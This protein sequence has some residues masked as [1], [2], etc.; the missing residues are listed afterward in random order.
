MSFRPLTVANYLIIVR[1]KQTQISA[2]VVHYIQ[3]YASHHS[4]PHPARQL[5]LLPSHETRMTVYREYLKYLSRNDPSHD[6]CVAAPSPTAPN[7]VVKVPVDDVNRRTPVSATTFITI[8]KSYLPH[9]RIIS[10]RSDLCDTCVSFLRRVQLLRMD[11]SESGLQALT[12]T[13]EE[14]VVHRRIAAEEREYYNKMIRE[15][16][17]ANSP[18]THLSFDYSQKVSLPYSAQQVG[19]AYFKTALSV[20]VFG[21][22]EE[23]CRRCQLFLVPEGM[24][25][26]GGASNSEYKSHVG[27]TGCNAVIS[28]LHAA[29]LQ[30]RGPRPLQLRL[31]ADNCSGQN[32]NNYVLGYLCWAVLVGLCHDVE[33]SFM[34]PGHTKFSC[35]AYFGIFKSKLSKTDKCDDIDDLKEVVRYVRNISENP[36]P[37]QTV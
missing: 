28:Q 2:I 18:I 30:H 6:V 10:P 16:A 31:H 17:E 8:W 14:W 24:E 15:A 9:I 35:D 26:A 3:S 5:V 7:G 20:H 22:A 29:L 33:I 13:M 34:I 25:L 1:Y 21:V 23:A 19:K 32:K 4:L 12:R 27:G 36:P 11:P 37:N